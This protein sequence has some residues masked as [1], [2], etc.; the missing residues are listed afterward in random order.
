M[1]PSTTNL[2]EEKKLIEREKERN[3]MIELRLKR[4]KRCKIEKER[5]W[6]LRMQKMRAK[7]KLE[8]SIIVT[9]DDPFKSPQ[10]LGKALKKSRVALLQKQ[11][12]WKKVL[13]K[14]IIVNNSYN[15]HTEVNSAQLNAK[16]LQKRK[17]RLRFLRWKIILTSLNRCMV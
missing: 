5:K 11:H 7:R 3:H 14:Q 4:K 9:S 15:F 16:C 6:K 17:F 2:S 1:A 13:L 8:T 10:N 12:V